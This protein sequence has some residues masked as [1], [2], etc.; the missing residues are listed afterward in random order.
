MN[1]YPLLAN[2][3]VALAFTLVVP[4][5]AFAA[6]DAVPKTAPQTAKSVDVRYVVMLGGHDFAGLAAAE[7]AIINNYR[8]GL[9]STDE[10]SVQLI[11][12]VSPFSTSYIPD[13]ELWVKAQPKSYAARLGLGRL[14]L[15]AAWEA[16]GANYVSETSREQFANMRA[17]LRKAEENLLASIP[18]FEKPYS[19]YTNLINVDAMLSQTK[20][21]YYL[22]Q[23]IKID[24]AAKLAY[25]RYILYR[26]PRWGGSYKELDTLLTEIKKGPML[27]QDQADLE[28]RVLTLKA[29]DEA[30][31]NPTNAI[32][33]Y[34]QAYERFPIQDEV[35]RLYWAADV[36]K[37]IKQTKRALEIY[38][39]IIDTYP[40][41]HRAFFGRGY[42][43]DQ[44]LNYELALKDFV[45]SAK[46][47]NKY[48][49]NNAGYYYMVGRGGTKDL[50][51]A[52]SYLSQ[53]AEQGFEHAKE[54]LKVLEGM[55]AKGAK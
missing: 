33:L 21:R 54:K 39:R 41:E 40:D 49:Q 45:A 46:L 16:R 42:L 8:K 37:K 27:P 48:A 25:Q 24:P 7:K 51:L 44:M 53:S 15:H 31:H 13:A 26:I 18:L 5:A 47:G 2:G 52:K 35:G 38:T 12:L 34:I 10:F 19:S 30:T 9:I 6:P 3:V 22:D 23:A 50:A 43:Y 11:E 28:A 1:F 36:A 4:V 14:Y 32:D 17:L 29:M 20:M 55:M